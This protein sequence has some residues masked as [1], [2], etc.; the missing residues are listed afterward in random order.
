MPL[1]NISCHLTD[2]SGATRRYTVKIE[3]SSTVQQLVDRI[4]SRFQQP[5]TR[6]QRNDRVNNEPAHI[7]FFDEP[8]EAVD[9]FFFGFEQVEARLFNRPS[10]TTST[11]PQQCQPVESTYCEKKSP[12]MP[13]LLEEPQSNYS[14]PYS[15]SSST[16]PQHTTPAHSTPSHSTPQY[17]APNV[18]SSSDCYVETSNHMTNALASMTVEKVLEGCKKA[19]VVFEKLKRA[20]T[21]LPAER[22]LL[23]RTA[24]RWLM[25]CCAIR[26]KPTSAERAYFAKHFF[27]KLPNFQ[28]EVKD[29]HNSQSRGFLD[30]FIYNERDRKSRAGELNRPFIPTDALVK[31]LKRKF[32]KVSDGSGN[33]FDELNVGPFPNELSVPPEEVNQLTYLEED[34]VAFE[35]RFVEVII[36]DYPNFSLT[37]R[38]ADRWQYDIAPKIVKYVKKINFEF[39]NKASEGIAVKEEQHGLIALK[40]VPF[41]VRRVYKD[42]SKL[43]YVIFNVKELD[44][45]VMLRSMRER[46]DAGPVIFTD[47]IEYRIVVMDKMIRCEQSAALALE[48]LLK[49]YYVYSLPLNSMRKTLFLFILTFFNISPKATS[50]FKETVKCIMTTT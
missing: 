12:I 43:S 32:S 16:T 17:T 25:D 34:L 13:V 47:N 36:R 11:P 6:I 22:Q 33:R 37:E 41:L 40:L 5:L 28:Y 4:Q 18:I 50:A 1:I 9:E 10:P 21:I 44:V 27:G 15:E 42:H 49:S 38:L 8:V 29:F 20:E 23:V 48:K 7:L 39:Y 14:N 45:T 24:G 35:N 31:T 46:Q 2:P 30:V 26:M 3:E 19:E